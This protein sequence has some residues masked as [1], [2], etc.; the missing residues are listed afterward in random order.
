VPLFFARWLGEPA[1]FRYAVTVL[2]LMPLGLTL[3]VFFPAGLREVRT[4]DELLV[5]WA[6]GAN[7]AASAVG[8]ILSIVLAISVGFQVVLFIPAGVYLIGLIAFVAARPVQD[9]VRV[10]SVG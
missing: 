5:P 7:G 6:W 3:G 2:L 8:S 1:A 9:V 10:P 4:R